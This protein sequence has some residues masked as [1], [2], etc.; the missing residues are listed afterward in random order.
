L[1]EVDITCAANRGKGRDMGSTLAFKWDGASLVHSGGKLSSDIFVVP[2]ALVLAVLVCSVSGRSSNSGVPGRLLSE[3]SS[4]PATRASEIPE[5]PIWEWDI[6]ESSWLQSLF[7]LG[8]ISSDI[9][10]S[11]DSRWLPP[12]LV[13]FVLL[14]LP[15]SEECRLSLWLS[16]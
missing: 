7:V 16:F 11:S 9:K 1:G 12:W 5:E 15:E 14:L 4:A 3:M 13:P 8:D 2:G 10:A 6:T